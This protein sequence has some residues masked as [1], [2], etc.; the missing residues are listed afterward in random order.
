MG[1]VLQYEHTHTHTHTQLAAWPRVALTTA[2]RCCRSHPFYP[3]WPRRDEVSLLSANHLRVSAPP[4]PPTP[5]PSG[6]VG[7]MSFI[8]SKGCRGF[9]LDMDALP[10]NQNVAAFCLPADSLLSGAEGPPPCC[11][12]STINRLRWW[13]RGHW[14]RLVTHVC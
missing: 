12:S 6:A 4:P 11:V 14:A 8:Q 7:F 3:N 13:R 1:K 10:P 9:G 2:C 5:H